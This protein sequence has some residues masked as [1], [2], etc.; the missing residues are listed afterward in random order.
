MHLQHGGARAVQFQPSRS[1]PVSQSTTTIAS[2]IGL[3]SARQATWDGHAIGARQSGHATSEQK[4]RGWRSL[5]RW[6]RPATGGR[7]GECACDGRMHATVGKGNV[8]MFFLRNRVI[9]KVE[10]RRSVGPIVGQAYE[11]AIQTK[12]AGANA[13]VL[14]ICFLRKSSK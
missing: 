14:V 11:R 3:G 1:E 9:P 13:H 5:P 2:I 8:A 6:R 12:H 4:G 10:R 7:H